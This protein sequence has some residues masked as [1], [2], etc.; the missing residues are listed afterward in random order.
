MTPIMTRPKSQT[1]CIAYAF[2]G[3]CAL[4]YQIVWYHAFID[5]FGAAGTTFLVVLCTF[6]GALGAGS[7]ASKR[8]Y[9]WLDAR[10]GGHGLKNYGRTELAI[11]LSVTLL[12][13]ITKLSLESILGSFPYH[14]EVINGLSLWIPDATYQVLRVILTILSVGVP[15]FFMGLTF[16]Y[17]C[18]VYSDEKT[19]PSRLY[20]ANT[21]GACVAAFTTEFVGLQTLGYIGCLF[22]AVCINVVIALIFLSAGRSEPG[23]ESVQDQAQTQISIYPGILSGL[24]CGGVQVLAYVL[25]KLTLGP[26]KAGFALLAFF[27]IFGIWL[28][29][30][31]VHRFHPSRALLFMLSCLGLLWTAA[32]WFI[33]PRMSEWFVQFGIRTLASWSSYNAAFLATTATIGVMILIPYTLWSM[34]LPDLCDRLQSQGKNLSFA[35]GVNT[36]SFLVGV[37]IFGWVLQNIHFF[38]AARTF[39]WFATIGLGLLAFDS[40]TPRISAKVV[41]S[42]VVLA[43]LGVPFLPKGLEMRLVGGLAPSQKIVAAYRSTSQHL[44]WVRK[45]ADGGALMFDRHSMSGTQMSSQTYMR[46]MAHL[47]LLL[48]SDPQNVLLI[49]F[50]VGATADA[51]RMHDSVKHVDIVDLNPSVFLLNSYFAPQNNHVLSDPR[52]RLICDDGRQFLKFGSNK[53]DFVTM[54]PPPPLQPG[55]SRL[56]S[57]EYYQQIREHLNEGGI[58]SQWLSESQLDQRGVDLI[59]RTFVQSF[60]HSFLFVGCKRELILVGSDKPFE[61][62]RVAQKLKMLPKVTEDLRRFKIYQP[63]QFIESILR[64]DEGMR[65]NWN[66]G[67]II[68]DGFVSLEGIQVSP[69]Q[70]IHPKSQFAAYKPNLTYDLQG[71]HDYFVQSQKTADEAAALA[72]FYADPSTDLEAV[73]Y[74]PQAY[75]PHIQK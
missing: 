16:P 23:I 61:F 42:G 1:V 14:L 63:M 37:L 3:A 5:Q 72:A 49:C 46:A 2:G 60:E 56:Y 67:E 19:F 48:N 29:S 21:L 58:V 41:A 4:I 7:F 20:A 25:L 33:E 47:P 30:T 73:K 50:G 22:L 64:I 66:E 8:L 35:Y 69:V 15:C 11:A 75:F 71:V 31:I 43:L 9:S 34:L 70:Q 62:S 55:I 54:E 24:L 59:C 68:Q 10:I 27:C 36:I 65:R 44:F 45:S 18:S 38:F 51:I 53:Y 40:F 17:L 57:E 12:F 26:T 6:I 52:I 74:I 13:G 28:A 39:A 32:I